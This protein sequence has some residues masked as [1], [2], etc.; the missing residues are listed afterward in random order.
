MKHREPVP[1]LATA[2]GSQA[3]GWQLPLPVDDLLVW[4]WQRWEVE[5]AHRELKRGFGVGEM[6]CWHPV[7][8]STTVQRG[9]WLYAL[10]LLAGYG[11]W[12]VCGGP[13]PLGPWR[14]PV[15]RWSFPT[16]WRSLRTAEAGLPQIGGLWAR[17]PSDWGRKEVWVAQFTCSLHTTARL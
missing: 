2:Q 6:Q 1:V 13:P 11:R 14:K 5:V 8:A 4:L 3:A 15:G 17:T 9:I 16:L 12:G 10:C 7:S